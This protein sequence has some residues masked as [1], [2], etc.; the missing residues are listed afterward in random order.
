[1]TEQANQHKLTVYYDGAC[2]LCRREIK[3]YRSMQG[4]D[5]IRWQDV[6]NT[7]GERIA[8]DLSCKAALTRFHVRTPDGELLSGASAFAELWLKLPRFKLL[9]A[10]AKLPGVRA[11][12]ERTYLAFLKLRPW[13]QKRCRD[14]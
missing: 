14:G 3:W 10:T 13:L 12:A 6:S 11:I 1:M 4:S 8:A 9:G 7:E 2:P 5:A